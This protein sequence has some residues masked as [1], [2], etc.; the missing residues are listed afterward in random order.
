[1]EMIDTLSY[2]QNTDYHEIGQYYF[3]Q[4]S[5][6]TYKIIFHFR[7]KEPKKECPL[8]T[9]GVEPIIDLVISNI[10]ESLCTLEVSAK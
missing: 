2:S 5:K 6:W 1:M 3:K 8:W 4:F 7:K 10:K 9:N